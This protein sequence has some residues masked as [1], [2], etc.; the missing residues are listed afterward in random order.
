MASPSVAARAPRRLRVVQIVIKNT[1][2]LDYSA[3]LLWKLRRDSIAGE[4]T[5]LYCAPSRRQ[6]LRD[7]TFYP[8][9]FASLGIR[10]VD[11]ADFPKRFLSP[12]AQMVERIFAASPSDR[13]S[14]KGSLLALRSR[15]PLPKAA[16]GLLG[17]VGG[18]LKLGMQGL[19]MRALAIERIL[20][21]LD[22][23]VVLLG[24]RSETRFYKRD[25]FYRYYDRAGRPVVLLPH[26][27]HEVH[28]VKEFIPFDERGEALPPYCDFWSSLRFETPELNCPGRESQFAKIG[29]PGLDSEWMEFLGSSRSPVPSLPSA[30]PGRLRCLLILRKF[31]P[32]GYPRPINFDPFT[33][34]YDDMLSHLN[35]VGDAL[36]GRRESVEVVIKPHP[37]NNF[38]ML[39][40]ILERSTIKHWVISAEPMY[41]LLP[42]ID[43]AISIFSTSMLLPAMYGRPVIVLNSGLQQYVHERW[44]K[45][46]D[47]YTGLRYYLEDSA[48]LS[49]TLDMVCEEVK[50]VGRRR[51]PRKTPDADHLRLFFPDGALSAAS[52]RLDFLLA[53]TGST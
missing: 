38:P 5:V 48:Q 14:L 10:E 22:P 11:F 7:S 3:P 37:S 46:A 35:L 44:S 20:P 28:P 49:P 32:E 24:N 18:A 2:E 40:A 17:A 25:S 52:K 1:S 29:Y 39:K 43:F 47:L 34:D 27:T 26:G 13:P 4:V 45:L 12:I 50:T 23:D 42:V 33:L 19:G 30:A 41:P 53:S 51:L 31:L 6:Y 9:L 36:A 16:R 15:E 21:T 8:E